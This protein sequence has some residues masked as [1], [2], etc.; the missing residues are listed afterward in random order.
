[1]A[2]PTMA[3]FIDRFP[4]LQVHSFAQR[5]EALAAAGRRCPESV[6]A[7]LQFDGACFYAAHLIAS[8]VREVGAQVGQPV[9]SAGSGLLSTHYGQQFDE[10]SQCLPCTS[11]FSI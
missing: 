11:G 4:E 3:Q 7:D 1:M 5:D 8:R 6:W 10:L 9:Q 2:I